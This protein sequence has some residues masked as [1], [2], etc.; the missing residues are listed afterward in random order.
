MDI[1]AVF[2]DL[3]VRREAIPLG[4]SDFQ[5]RHFVVGVQDGPA[6]QYRAALLRAQDRRN[7]IEEAQHARAVEDIDIEELEYEITNKVTAKGD[8]LS[9]FDVRRKRLDLERKQK[10]RAYG[11]KL[12]RDALAELATLYDVIRQH[13]AYTRD[14]FEALEAQHYVS[15]LSRQLANAHL[16]A[17]A[18]AAESLTAL[19]RPDVIG[20]APALAPPAEPAAALPSQK[21]TAA[22]TL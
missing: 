2:A 5:N 10:A 21:D 15:N 20:V 3:D 8:P 6:R 9:D 4:N 16:G 13:P 17:A 18:G 19:Q 7:A 14:D 12:I 22:C 11:D 1:D